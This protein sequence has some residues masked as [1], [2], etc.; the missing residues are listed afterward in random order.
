M[1]GIN[2]KQLAEALNLSTSTISRAFR[3]SSGIKQHTKDLILSKAKE[4]NY[5][6]NHYASNLRDQKSKTIA[7]IVPE[8]ANNY[9][10]QAIHGIE[11]VARANG[12]NILI[13][14]TDDDLEKEM[15]F[16]KHLHNGRV[17]GIIMSVSGE[18]ENHNYLNDFGAR[19]LP[20]VQFDRVYDDI[21][22]PK[23]ITDD[24][25]SSFIATEHLIEQGCKRIGYL[26]VKKDLSIG[27]TREMGYIDALKKHHIN[28]KEEL[29]IDCSNSYTENDPIIKKALKD[30]KL[31][32]IFAS[33]ERLAFA[34]YYA[35]YD[36]NIKIPHDLKVIS[37]SSLEIAPL[38]NPSLTTITQ[39]AVEIGNLSAKLL[40][41][42][43]QDKK[44]ISFA[45]EKVVLNSKIIFRNSTKSA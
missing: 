1:D 43:L 6:P 21:D 11:Q 13:Y 15:D 37:F 32:G 24:Y 12:Y 7:V 41:D 38:L 20:M 4:L 44:E 27:K 3:N 2:I 26:V 14:S 34:T 45:K 16:I 31:D 29:I 39:P 22:T 5:Q 33:V 42:I 35:S 23:I 17:E 18:A 28:Y 10:S 36:L 9:F 40:F 30:L 8:L 25:E 19:R